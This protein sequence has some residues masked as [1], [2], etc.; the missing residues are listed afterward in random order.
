MIGPPVLSVEDLTV[1]YA[2]PAGELTA[3][4][5]LSLSVNRGEVLGLVGESGCGK[6]SVALAVLRIL[7]TN[8]A[9]PE[10]R[11]YVDGAELLSMG[12]EAMRKVRGGVVSLVFQGAMNSLNPVHRVGDQVL[13][14]IEEH[15]SLSS[16]E[17]EQRIESLFEDLGLDRNVVDMYPHELSG[18]MKQRVVI[19]IAL[20][21]RP[22]LVIADEPTTALDVIVQDR[23]LRSIHEIRVRDAMSVVYISHDIAVI[24][25][26]SDSIAV[27]YA[28][29]L[30][31]E[32][33]TADVLSH[34]THP[35][36]RALTAAV[37]RVRGA[38]RPPVPLPG[39]PPDLMSPPK[40][41]RFHPRCEFATQICKEERPPMV[42]R[43]GVRSACWHP[44]G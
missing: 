5:G 23:I 11:I 3:V 27:M 21:C 30:V 44:L 32:G 17:A 26:V 4:D 13:E 2:V 1:R 10:G 36:T 15:T 19:A 37:P 16:L 31:E 38:R 35:Y 40:G 9:P 8:A 6:T 41:C 18:G 28:G 7:P 43:N 34:P 25:E 33:K 39:D 20:S 29:R 22:R 24:S 12:D 14:S 42:S